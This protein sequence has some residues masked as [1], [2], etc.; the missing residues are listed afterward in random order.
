MG[1]HLLLSGSALISPHKFAVFLNY[2]SLIDGF[3]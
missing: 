3:F 1:S 2:F